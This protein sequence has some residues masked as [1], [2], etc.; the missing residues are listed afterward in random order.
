MLGMFLLFIYLF[1][2]GF[3]PLFDYAFLVT[4]KGPGDDAAPVA[5]PPHFTR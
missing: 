2:I 3:S 4:V 1:F 5:T